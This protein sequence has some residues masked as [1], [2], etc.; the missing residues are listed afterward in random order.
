METLK[1]SMNYEKANLIPS[2]YVNHSRLYQVGYI[3]IS[4]S[5]LF[6]K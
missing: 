1:Q 3:N 2:S 4:N 5:L 6:Y